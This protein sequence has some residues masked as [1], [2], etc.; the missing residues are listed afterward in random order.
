MTIFVYLLSA[1]SGL[2]GLAWLIFTFVQPP[3]SVSHYFRPPTFLYF[4]PGEAPARFT[5]ALVFG[6]VI[7]FFAS[8]IV[9]MFA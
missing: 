6:G 8:T 2:Y 7:P 1:I 3:S 9:A 5:M 4:L